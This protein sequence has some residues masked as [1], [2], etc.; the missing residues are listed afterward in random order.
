MYRTAFPR[1]EVNLGLMH[2]ASDFPE[3]DS[4]IHPAVKF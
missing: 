4:Y 2:F 1:S 3:D